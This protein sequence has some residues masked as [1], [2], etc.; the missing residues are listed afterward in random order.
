MKKYHMRKQMNWN[1]I[2]KLFLNK[3]IIYFSDYHGA[4]ETLVMSDEHC[5]HCF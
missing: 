3:T 2:Q 4:I 5:F 1:F